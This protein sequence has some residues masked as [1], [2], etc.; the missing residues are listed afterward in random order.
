MK[1]LLAV[2]AESANAVAAAAAKLFPEADYAVF[3]SVPFLP[4]VVPDTLVSAAGAMVPSEE[5]LL[6][7]EA[8]GDAASA[9]ARQVLP[10]D[11]T[12]AVSTPSAIPGRR[13]AKRR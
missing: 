10:S 4:T 6:A 12:E 11:D 13:S 9:A 8:E 7:A 2:D 3:N 1:L 5:A